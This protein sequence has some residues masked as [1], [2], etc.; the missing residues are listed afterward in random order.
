M[1]YSGVGTG[2]YSRENTA[3]AEPDDQ[4][5]STSNA[6]KIEQDSQ[7]F[8]SQ[9][10]HQQQLLLPRQQNLP[11]PPPQPPTTCF[12]FSKNCKN[13]NRLF[14]ASFDEDSSSSSNQDQG[15]APSQN[16]DTKV[17][18]EPSG[19]QLEI[20]IETSGAEESAKAEVRHR[21]SSSIND[22]FGIKPDPILATST[23]YG[24]RD[25]NETLHLIK[26]EDGLPQT[27]SIKATTKTGSSKKK[28]RIGQRKS[29]RLPQQ[30]TSCKTQEA[31]IM[32]R[33][34]ALTFV[35]SNFSNT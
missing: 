4:V 11:G 1:N 16:C 26:Q 31:Q 30:S 17:K 14:H 24:H 9:Y 5:L 35:L 27:I 3:K 8:L 15:V 12:L 7:G 25:R 19:I 22:L 34:T 20:E 21:S 6:V 33:V 18:L 23:A 29:N 28:G 10:H 2:S 13:F 32:R